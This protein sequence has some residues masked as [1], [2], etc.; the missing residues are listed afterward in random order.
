MKGRVN[1]TN[2]EI[3]EK[4]LCEVMEHSERAGI[5]HSSFWQG[6][7]YGLAYALDG[8]ENNVISY[9]KSTHIGKVEA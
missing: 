5:R 2:T 9:V 7:A 3:L 1:M 4:A 8:M 6:V